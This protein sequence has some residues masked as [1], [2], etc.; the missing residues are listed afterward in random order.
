MRGMN[1]LQMAGGVA[2]AGVVAAG[3]TAYTG[4]G[5]TP[6]TDTTKSFIGG[7]ATQLVYGA[8]IDNVAYTF[9]DGT[10][11]VLTG[12]TVTF[13]DGT[14]NGKTPTA[15]ISVTGGS[16]AGAT[17]VSCGAVSAAASAC[18]LAS[19]YTLGTVNSVAIT[20]I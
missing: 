11:T 20:V 2:V 8:T 10:K 15:T 17:T 5:I 3:A 9:T 13:T 14:V 12:F 7:T 16:W 6:T 4:S 1:L 19:D 18:T